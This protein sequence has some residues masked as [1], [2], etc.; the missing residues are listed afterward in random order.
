MG[1]HKIE[2]G[3]FRINKVVKFYEHSNRRW[4]LG[5]PEEVEALRLRLETVVANEMSSRNASK[6]ETSKNAN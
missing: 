4:W 6:P 1:C 3:S 5:V 2:R